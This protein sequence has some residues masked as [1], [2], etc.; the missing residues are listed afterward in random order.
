M[1]KFYQ[2][3][4]KIPVLETQCLILREFRFSDFAYLVKTNADP[5][6]KA[7]HFIRALK[8]PA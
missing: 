7:V 8:Q 1:T 6:G 3:E 5:G 4:A 2:A